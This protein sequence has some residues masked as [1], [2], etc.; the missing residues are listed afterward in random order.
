MDDKARDSHPQD[1]TDEEGLEAEPSFTSTELPEVIERP[2][3]PLEIK[4]SRRIVTV[5]LITRRIEYGEIELA[6]DF[7]RRARIWDVV[8]KSK[9]IE[10]ILLRIPLPVFYVAADDAE[11]WR[12][13]DGL[14]RL[15]TIYDFIHTETEHSFSLR[16]L[17]YLQAYEGAT[18]DQL[19]RSIKR[20]IDET[21]LNINVIESGT[22]DEVMFNV[23]KRI[24]TGGITL[25]GQE[26]RHALNPGPAREFLATLAGCPEFKA[27]TDGSVSDQ[28]MGA[29]ELAL[30]FSAFILIPY[31]QYS[32][33]NLDGFLNE[34]M[35]RLNHLSSSE[36]DALYERFKIS[37]VRARALFNNDAFRKRFSPN[38][39]R[40]PINRA[41]FEAWSVP[42]SGMSKD[43]FSRLEINSELLNSIFQKALNTNQFF[44]SSI[45]ISTGSRARVIERFSTIEKIIKEVLG[46]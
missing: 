28:R 42:L 44:L 27:A 25:N 2:F 37:M 21:E 23:F 29:R 3:D 33:G 6:P 41:L 19:P 18:F 12:V 32:E 46:A 7:Q 34:A 38:A 17:E 40:T 16:G 13:V 30:R 11:N 20:R 36:L 22:P 26:I 9:L 35:K 10:S 43:D 39:G 31:Q 8:R 24:N 4:I 1:G 45:S 14:Q 5:G 15:T